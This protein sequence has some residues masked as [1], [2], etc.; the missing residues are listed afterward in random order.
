LREREE[1][2][3]KDEGRDRRKGSERYI[4]RN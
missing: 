2:N 3:G 1:E 4:V